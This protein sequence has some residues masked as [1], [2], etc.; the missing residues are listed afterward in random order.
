MAFFFNFRTDVT[1]TYYS[2][3]FNKHEHSK[4]KNPLIKMTIWNYL[5]IMQQT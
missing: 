5:N 3:C 2:I 4:L 1:I